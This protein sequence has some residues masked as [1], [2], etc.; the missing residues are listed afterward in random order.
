MSGRDS[1][2]RRVP[3][4][5]RL[6][7]QTNHPSHST[8]PAPVNRRRS[9]RPVNRRLSK[10]SA[11]IEI[12]KRSHSDPAFW[13]VG[14]G[15]DRNLTPPADDEGVLYRPQTCA[16]IFSPSPS[17]YSFLPRS[18]R[19]SLEVLNQYLAFHWIVRSFLS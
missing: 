13:K 11:P 8:S 16:D 14:G 19:K 4:S 12:L 10:P 15:G 2:K 3:V 7:R 9:S 1:F 18:P 17:E 5:R 6:R